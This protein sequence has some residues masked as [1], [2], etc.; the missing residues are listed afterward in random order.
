MC[1]FLFK[2]K[3]GHAMRHVYFLSYELSVHI[4]CPFLFWVIGL[5]LTD[6]YNKCHRGLIGDFHRIR[7]EAP[8]DVNCRYFPKF[9]FELFLWCFVSQIDFSF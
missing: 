8:C 9:F 3:V 4:I 5:Y 1:D 6:S 7:K 2:N